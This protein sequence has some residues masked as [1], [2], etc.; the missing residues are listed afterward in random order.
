MGENNEE[1][2]KVRDQPVDKIYKI[3]VELMDKNPD[4]PVIMI[5]DVIHECGKSGFTNEQIYEAI[6]EYEGMNVWVVNGA[7]TKLT[8]VY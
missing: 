3:V 2:R 8:R 5:D 1:S 4:N 6:D 7:R